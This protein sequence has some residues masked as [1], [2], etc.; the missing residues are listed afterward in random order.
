M[1]TICEECG[2]KYKIDPAKITGTEAKFKCKAC[3]HLITAYKPPPPD[4]GQNR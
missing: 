4:R 3:G 1:I 2:K